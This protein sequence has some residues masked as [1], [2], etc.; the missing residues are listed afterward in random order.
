[1]L[2]RAC[3]REREMA[4]RSAIGASR[5]R[6]V[7]QALTEAM[8]LSLAAS[9]AGLLLAYGLIRV[10][11]AMAPTS[12]PYLDRAG[13]DLRVAAFSVIASLLC[14]AVFGLIPALQRPREGA[15]AARTA[16]G[17]RHATLR[18]TL[19]AAQIAVSMVLLAA[20]SLLVQSFARMEHQKLGFAAEGVTTV[21]M[22][23]PGMRT[24]S[25]VGMVSRHNDHEVMDFYLRAEEAM[26][27]LPGVRAVGYS[28]SFP[29]G[30]G[31]QNRRRLSDMHV[32]G[33]EVAPQSTGGTVRW[34][35]VT[36]EYFH[37][38]EI[39]I[40]RGRGFT[41]QDR[42][43]STRLMIV[44]EQAAQLLSPKLSSG[45]EL[46]GKQ[47][48]PGTDD[49]KYTIVGV[50]KDVRNG[51][52]SDPQIP[53]IYELR[54]NVTDDWGTPMPVMVIASAQS[55]QTMGPWIRTEI[56]R[57]NPRVSVTIE[58]LSRRIEKL[59][60]RPRFETSLLGFFAANGLWMAV[61]GLYGVMAYLA[62]QRTQE[63]GVRMALGAGRADI[64]WMV[65]REGLRLIALGGTIGLI[66]ALFLTRML[67]SLLYEVGPRDPAA[68]AGSAALLG[69]AAMAATLVPAMRAMRVDPVEALRSE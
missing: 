62:V 30:G 60:D 49:T 35:T 14:G 23:F 58:P 43:G 37:A 56:A 31:W 50:A 46:L 29:P 25:V 7:R 36:P 44:S 57:I 21:A 53:E 1:M 9:I 16:G 38:L 59:A 28:D 22:T 34:R 33:L 47:I 6:L 8:L 13:I 10:F 26:R 64:L 69:L 27:R 68:L 4:V 15:L 42:S 67:G 48:K 11:V 40:V 51:G 12:V 5:A 66:G 63:I 65:A 19:V 41:E 32:D 61:L 54:Q 39:P 2:T 3:S 52:L 17:A 45:E 55:T 18:R 20:G 24:G